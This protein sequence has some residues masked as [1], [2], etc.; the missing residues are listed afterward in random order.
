VFDSLS[1][2]RQLPGRKET[3]LTDFQKHLA[4]ALGRLCLKHGAGFC[5]AEMGSKVAQTRREVRH[6]IR[7]ITAKPSRLGRKVTPWEV[8]LDQLVPG[9]TL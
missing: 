9:L 1:R 5:N 6:S 8:A 2:S 7:L 3:G 4:I